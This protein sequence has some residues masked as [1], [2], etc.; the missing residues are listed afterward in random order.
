MELRKAQVEALRR[1]KGE[2]GFGYFMEQGLGKT[3]TTL[4]DFMEHRS[5]GLVSN[6]LVISP[7]SFKGGWV[8]EIE[9]SGMQLHPVI[10]NSSEEKYA[11]MGLKRGGNA[12]KVLIVNWEAIRQ[13]HTIDFIMKYIGMGNVY[14]VGDESIQIKDPSAEQTKAALRL[15]PAFTMSRILSG[16]PMSQGPHDMWAQMRFIGQLQNK[17]F[18]PF[19]TMFCR[20]G[21]FKMK[22]VVGSQNDEYLAQL[23][24]PHVFRALKVDYTD[25]PPKIYTHREYAM[26]AE[27]A[28]MYKQM[29]DEFVLWLNDNENIAV[30][31]AI[32]KYIK[33]AQIQMGFILDADGKIHWLVEPRSN[34]RINLLRNIADN[35]VPG[36]LIVVYNH[37]PVRELLASCFADKN[38]T[39][40]HGGMTDQEIAQNKRRFNEDNSCRIIAITKAAKYGHTLLGGPEFEN[41]CSTM[42]FLE[43]TYSLD[44]RS[45]LE[46]RPHRY[47]QLGSAMLYID[48]VG[49]Q[50]DR[51][52][53]AALQRKENVFQSV[54]S[55]LR[56]QRPL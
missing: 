54:F 10:Y 35:E 23:I 32:T 48:I 4:C 34:P 11:A 12:P 14:G 43:N 3:F 20:M 51:N 16:K 29:E 27:Q 24:E 17:L 40:I 7:N 36:K 2:K 56:N 8:E 44:D 6:M 18:Y 37:K 38:I 22:K 55:R 13:Q 31:A 5:E 9:K 45:Q 46:D 19:K 25:L 1:S 42:V 41:H 15:A 33:L 30:D 49:T 39:F 50:L 47:G 26:G 21:G 52:A 53:T 28:R